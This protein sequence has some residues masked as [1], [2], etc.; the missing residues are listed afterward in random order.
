MSAELAAIPAL[1]PLL[2]RAVTGATA[3]PDDRR[4]AHQRPQLSP[5]TLTIRFCMCARHFSILQL[6]LLPALPRLGRLSRLP[7]RRPP[8]S[9]LPPTSNQKEGEEAF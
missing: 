9:S 1:P 8:P 5:A 2:A 7:L 3:R 4:C 6:Q